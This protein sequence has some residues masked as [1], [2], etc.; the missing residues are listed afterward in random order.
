MNLLLVRL[1]SGMRNLTISWIRC[2]YSRSYLFIQNVRVP[3]GAMN[4]GYFSGMVNW[5]IFDSFVAELSIG[6]DLMALARLVRFL[7]SVADSCIM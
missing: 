2:C 1:S 3:L 4:L 6:W 7:V 5:V